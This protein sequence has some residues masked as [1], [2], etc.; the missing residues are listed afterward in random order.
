MVSSLT[1]GILL[2]S[3]HAIFVVLRMFTTRRTLKIIIHNFY[4]FS[5]AIG[6]LYDW[7]MD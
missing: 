2:I 3:F 4:F 1:Y 7:A 6:T 5:E